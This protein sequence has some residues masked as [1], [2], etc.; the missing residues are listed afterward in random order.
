MLEADTLIKD[1]APSWKDNRTQAIPE[2]TSCLQESRRSP[3]AYCFVQDK[4]GDLYSPTAECKVASIIKR[5]NLVGQLEG[6]AFD[7]INRWFRDSEAG[8]AVWISPQD[9]VY[10]PTSKLIIS[11]ILHP[12]SQKRLLNRAIILNL[13]YEDCLE[14]AQALAERSQNRPLLLSLNSVR[15]TPLI[16][17]AGDWIDTLKELI[18]APEIWEK[19]KTGQDLKDQEKALEQAERIYDSFFNAEQVRDM[20]GQGVVISC[21]IRMDGLTAFK[22]FLAHSNSSENCPEICCNICS[23]VA[24]DEEVKKIQAGQLTNCPQ[25]GW[26]P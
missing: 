7:F 5:D 16:F 21:P 18:V 20:F 4:D 3:D 8:A 15:S 10:Y 2:I 11:E 13:R 1:F 12:N 22:A 19:I 25:C 24:N 14:R 6:Q 26:K 23:W 9:S 17:S